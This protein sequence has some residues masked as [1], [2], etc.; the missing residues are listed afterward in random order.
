MVGA[1]ESE[2][3]WEEIVWAC[4]EVRGLVEGGVELAESG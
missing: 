1:A 4:I 3:L 2:G